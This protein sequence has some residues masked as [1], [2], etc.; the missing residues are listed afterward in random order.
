MGFA[1]EIKPIAKLL[2][3]KTQAKAGIFV[4]RVYGASAESGFFVTQ[5]SLQNP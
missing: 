2:V 4:L 3:L 1:M 5:V